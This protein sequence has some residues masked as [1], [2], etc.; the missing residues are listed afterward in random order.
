LFRAAVRSGKSVSSSIMTFELN[1]IRA[2]VGA[3]NYTVSRSFYR[4]L[5]FEEKVL[6]DSLSLF[7]AGA[8]GFYLQDY[9][10]KEWLENTMLFL[11]VKDVQ[12][13]FKDVKAL[14][15]DKKYAEIK[16]MPIKNEDWGDVFYIIDPAGVL[17]HIA[18]FSA[19]PT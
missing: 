11:E 18:Q 10:N 9:N 8:L 13:R 12:K 16:I 5:G 1:S 6:S 2:F 4:D 7:Q 15:L 19:E 17:L 3:K 14:E